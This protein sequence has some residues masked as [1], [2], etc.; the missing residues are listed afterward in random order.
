M[1]ISSARS[2]S[3]NGIE[4]GASMAILGARAILVAL[5][6]WVASRGLKRATPSPKHGLL[7]IRAAGGAAGLGNS[8]GG[9]WK[10]RAQLVLER[11]H[12]Q[13]HFLA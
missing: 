10:F 12:Q 5:A 11:A 8:M 2:L 1:R 13:A 4:S 9:T 6:S 7:L 3:I